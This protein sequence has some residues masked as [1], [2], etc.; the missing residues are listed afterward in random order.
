MNGQDENNENAT[1]L[2][3]SF[4]ADS[5]IITDADG[6]TTWI[7]PACTELTGFT[8]T[9]MRGKRPGAMLQGPGTDLGIVDRLRQAILAKVNIREE[10]LNYHQSG[11]HYWLEL[12]ISPILD[13]SGTCTGFISVGRDITS[14][15]QAQAEAQLQLA[16]QQL[17][18]QFGTEFYNLPLA[19]LPVAIRRSLVEVSAFVRADAAFYLDL[20]FADQTGVV[21]HEWHQAELVGS[22]AETHRFPIADFPAIFYAEPGFGQVELLEARS[23]PEGRFRAALLAQGLVSLTAIPLLQDHPAQGVLVF[24]STA[25]AQFYP[26]NE[27]QL[28][29][30]FG[31]VLA[32]GLHRLHIEGE[33]QRAQNLLAQTNQAARIG[34]WEVDMVQGTVYWSDITRQIHEVAADYVPAPLFSD[35]LQERINFY[36]PGHSR[37]RIVKVMRLAI[38]EGRPF[39]EE[40]QV[41]TAKGRERW[42]RVVGEAQ[43]EQSTVRRI[44]GALYDIDEKKRTQLA[45]QQTKQ[46]L[47][48]IL[49]SLT[50]AVWAVSLPDYQI[51][52]ASTSCETLYG[53]TKAE[54]HAGTKS[55]VKAIVPEDRWVI[56]VMDRALETEG[57]Y[58]IE[59]RIATT[60]G[61]IKWVVNKGRLVRDESGRPVQVQGIIID[62]TASKQ[63]AQALVQAKEAAEAANRAKSEFVASMSHEIR[64]PLNGVV[65]F[66]NLLVQTDLNPVQQSYAR[67]VVLSANTLLAIVNDILDFSKI[68]AGMLELDIA[69][70]DLPDLLAQTSQVVAYQAQAKGLELRLSLAP[71]L[72]RFIWADPVRLRQVLINLLGNAV[73][74]TDRG[75]VELTAEIVSPLTDGQARCR[76]SVRDT[77]IGIAPANQRN[78]FAAFAQADISTTRNFGGTG[79]GLSISNQLLGL[80]G[81]Q[82]QLES[83]LGEGSTFYF[84][85][86]FRAEQ[87][88]GQTANDDHLPPTTLKTQGHEALPRA[89]TTIDRPILVLVVD[90]NPINVLLSIALIQRLAPLAKVV[91]AMDGSAALIHC[92][93][94]RPDLILMDVQMPGLSGYD[95]TAKIRQLAGFAAIPIVGCTAGNTMGEADR[96]LAA[97][98]NDFV[99]KPIVESHLAQVLTKWLHLGAAQ[100]PVI[101][102]GDEPPPAWDKLAEYRSFGPAFLRT[103]LSA[104]QTELTRA[105]AELA[106]IWATGDMGQLPKL[107]HRLVGGAKQLGLDALAKVAEELE[108]TPPSELAK[109]QLLVAATQVELAHALVLIARE[110]ATIGQ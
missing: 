3:V 28:L 48:E 51:I 60:K 23:L 53:L 84:E 78:I 55:W 97:G 91:G 65:G 57:W 6:L 75:E 88:N 52:F 10:I 19:Q 95:A 42:V 82:L 44:Y 43:I 27:K 90:D 61:A 56:S 25:P 47:Q 20:D 15:R 110:L 33:L 18:M 81:S 63:Y 66:A 73:K 9:D 62:M 39:D 72:P 50:D 5:I 85:V 1:S 74:F 67:N 77:G 89:P 8:L 58:A 93:S 98:M 102:E 40:L 107:A 108:T 13:G 34:G 83:S 37:D 104:S 86:S 99:S 94:Q 96:C 100:S 7:N 29:S 14:Q 87:A 36:K 22:L 4:V 30:A 69:Q 105:E 17:L 49:D 45:L 31:Q 101:G 70:V 41:V 16:R 38:A 80:M 26:E 68:E 54:L 92:D 64:T 2:A 109:I 46:Q 11:A 32:N 106:Q 76:F 24:G 71:D 79:L 35:S 21:A 59:Y 103:V 12:T